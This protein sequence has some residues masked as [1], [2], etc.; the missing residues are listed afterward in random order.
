MTRDQTMYTAKEVAEYIICRCN[1]TDVFVSNLKLQ[2][3]LYLVQVEYL[4]YFGR[5]CFSDDFEAWNVGPIVSDVYNRYCGFG[6]SG[7]ILKA[8]PK[9]A[10]QDEKFIDEIVQRWKN[11]YPWDMSR[12]TAYAGSPWDVTYDN[13]RGSHR[14]IR[15]ELI[16]ELEKA[17][18][19]AYA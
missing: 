17:K 7:I 6:G 18:E 12:K 16:K 11:A 1:L 14:I 4:R 13:G 19:V 2:K 5:P 9:I 15:K 8:E 10:G 3:L